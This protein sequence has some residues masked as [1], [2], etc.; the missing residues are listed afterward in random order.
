MMSGFGKKSPLFILGAKIFARLLASCFVFGLLLLL[1]ISIKSK[2]SLTPIQ[3]QAAA[4][5]I[6]GHRDIDLAS[7]IDRK[8]LPSLIEDID[9]AVELLQSIGVPRSS[10]CHPSSKV[11]EPYL[12][13]CDPTTSTN[14]SVSP[15]NNAITLTE[16]FTA[17]ALSSSR[18]E[19]KD[20][21]FNTPSSSRPRIDSSSSSSLSGTARILSSHRHRRSLGRYLFEGEAETPSVTA[22]EA[23]MP[24]GDEGCGESFEEEGPHDSI[25]IITHALCAFACVTIAALAAGLTMGLLSLDPLLL[26]IKMR[27]GSTQLE[28][29]QA[30]SLLPIVKQHHLL[31]VTLLLLNSLANEALPLFL[32]VLVSP[33]MAVILSV[34]FV[35]FFG[36]IIPSA[37][38]TGP[39]KIAIASKM[40]P[41]VRAVMF[42]LYPIAYPIAKALDH[43]L[44]DDDSGGGSDEFNRGELSAL[45]RIQYEERM[46]N[47]QQRKKERAAMA[48][49]AAGGGAGRVHN[50]DHSNHVG[51]LDF[52][53]SIRPSNNSGRAST[54][55]SVRA[56][57]REI[58]HRQS[59]SLSRKSDVAGVSV[60]ASGGGSQYGSTANT[61]A[62][63]AAVASAAAIPDLGKMSTPSLASIPTHSS[64]SRSASI[65]LDEVAMVEGALQMKTKM[66]FD[67]FTPLHRVFAI[68][69]SLVLDE[70]NIVTIYSRGYSRVP[71]YNDMQQSQLQ[72]EGAKST[73]TA[74]TQKLKDKTAI[75]GVLMTRQ[76]MIVNPTESRPVS[77]LPVRCV[78]RPSL[79]GLCTPELSHSCFCHTLLYS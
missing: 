41:I 58:E 19:R 7:R 57:K 8:S 37:V 69:L 79:L 66:A 61:I 30:A 34:T 35:L 23:I 68:P 45:V 53:S 71:V 49:G 40:T 54:R 28:K 77:T 6:V 9:S 72:A 63:P 38:F 43:I 31:L 48:T 27:A 32:E 44:H 46:A 29:D 64:P 47:K 2:S 55:Q 50:Y 75:C 4:E 42:L 67:V 56:F 22:G 39:N 26:L 70:P 62:A 65:H 20:G 17:M 21:G 15:P 60:S 16:E 10:L 14:N 11:Y 12:K 33:V 3:A 73:K 36:E 78:L 52:S 74:T 1:P 76:L 13:K 5:I 59:S 24:G 18:L 51:G 25:F